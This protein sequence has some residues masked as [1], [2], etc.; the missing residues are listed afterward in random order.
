M[1][2][3]LF[4]RKW[5]SKDEKITF[6]AAIFATLT[7]S[8]ENLGSVPIQTYQQFSELLNLDHNNK[9]VFKGRLNDYIGAYYRN[10]IDINYLVTKIDKLARKNKEW[11][12]EIPLEAIQMCVIRDE[13]LQRRFVEYIM[14]LLKE[15]SMNQKI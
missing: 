15:S 14:S 6:F 10:E 13:T 1:G 11:I 4:F 3:G 8:V 2:I 5:M 12:E 9:E 7:I